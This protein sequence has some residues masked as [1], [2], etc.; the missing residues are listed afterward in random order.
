[1]NKVHIFIFVEKHPCV[2]ILLFNISMK[3]S[4]KIFQFADPSQYAF[5]YDLIYLSSSDN[6]Q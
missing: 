1:M 4:V 6:Q 2:I 3:A 5:V